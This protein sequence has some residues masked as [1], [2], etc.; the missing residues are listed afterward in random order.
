MTHQQII[1]WLYCI[2]RLVPKTA[3][4]SNF[5]ADKVEGLINMV[6]MLLIYLINF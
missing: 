1:N 2:I 6:K 3:I 4:L 5:G